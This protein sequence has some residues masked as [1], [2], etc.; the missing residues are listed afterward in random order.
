V[1]PNGVRVALSL[2][3]DAVEAAVVVHPRAA[4]VLV[5][6]SPEGA[7]RLARAILRWWARAM[8]WGLKLRLWRWAMRRALRE[9]ARN[10]SGKPA[11]VHQLSEARRAAASDA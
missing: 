6:L 7:A 9:R 3:G 1:E 11:P 5:S 8:W 2:D 4:P 10:S